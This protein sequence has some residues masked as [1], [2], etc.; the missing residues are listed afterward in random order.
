MEIEVETKKNQQR[1][2]QSRCEYLLEI[3]EAA[4]SKFGIQNLTEDQQ[5]ILPII[6][7]A[8]KND[9]KL[10]MTINLPCG[11]TFFIFTI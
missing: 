8:M 3:Q 10:N 9:R 5:T 4:K 2:E 6:W 1:E 11:K 7:D